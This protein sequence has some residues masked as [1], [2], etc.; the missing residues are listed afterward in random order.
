[1]FCQNCGS[2]NEDNVKFC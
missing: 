1:M 2:E